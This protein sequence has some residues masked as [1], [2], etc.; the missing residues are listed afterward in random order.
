MCCATNSEDARQARFRLWPLRPRAIRS[1]ISPCRRGA[2]SCHRA[3]LRAQ[4]VRSLQTLRTVPSAATKTISSGT[5]VSFI[6]NSTGSSARRRRP[7]RYARGKSRDA[8]QAGFALRPR[9]CATSSV[10]VALAARARRSSASA[11][12]PA[13]PQ[14]KH[15]GKQQRDHSS[16]TIVSTSYQF[17]PDFSVTSSGT[18]SVD[19]LLPSRDARGWR[20]RCTSLAAHFED[21]LVVNLQQHRRIESGSRAARGR[22]CTI[23]S[24]MRSAALP[25]NGALV[26][27]RSAA[28]RS[29]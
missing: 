22:S 3:R 28:A 17:A 18:E 21:Q 16:S 8:H 29:M 4:P 1:R 11:A 20:A 24:F 25:C 27:S 12:A 19:A 2:E 10:S 7:C 15:R 13:S 5:S 23:A 6:Q 9:S 26:A 14:R